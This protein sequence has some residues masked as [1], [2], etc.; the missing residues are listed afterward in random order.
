MCGKLSLYFLHACVSCV[1]W[2][3]CQVWAC[4]CPRLPF[5]AVGVLSALVPRVRAARESESRPHAAAARAGPDRE[6]NEVNRAQLRTSTH[7]HAVC[8]PHQFSFLPSAACT[9]SHPPPSASRASRVVCA[10]YLC[11]P[12]C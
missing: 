11:W 1:H 5:A 8:T 10:A 3:K 7:S 12:R 2:W 4:I 9:H 6:M